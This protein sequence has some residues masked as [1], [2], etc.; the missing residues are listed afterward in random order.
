ML[1]LCAGVPARAATPA[2]KAAAAAVIAHFRSQKITDVQQPSCFIVQTWAQ[3]AYLEGDGEGTAWL[4]LKGGGWH[5]LGSD[6]G[7]IYAS[8]MVKRYG[9][10]LRS[11]S[12]FKPGSVRAPVPA[13]NAKQA[14]AEEVL[15][16]RVF[17]ARGTV[18]MKRAPP[19]G[20]CSSSTPPTA[21]SSTSRTTARPIPLPGASVSTRSPNANTRSRSIAAIPGPSSSTAIRANRRSARVDAHHDSAPGASVLYGVVD[22]VDEDERQAVGIDRDVDRRRVLDFDRHAAGRG[23]GRARVARRIERL[24]ERTGRRREERG[25]HVE[26]RDLEHP[27]DQPAEAER[28]V[29]R[30]AHE[31][32]AGRAVD[33]AVQQRLEVAANRRERRAELVPQ[34]REERIALAFLRA[35]LQSAVDHRAE[36]AARRRRCRTSSSRCAL[37]A[38]SWPPSSPRSAPGPSA[39][40][41]VPRRRCRHASARPAP[42][43]RCR[44]RRRAR[45]GRRLAAPA[46]PRSRTRP[47]PLARARAPRASPRR[48]ATRSSSGSCTTRTGYGSVDRAASRRSNASSRGSS[49]PDSAAC[50]LVSEAVDRL[51]E[52]GQL[53]AAPRA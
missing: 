30:D 22:E 49:P 13:P 42:R 6:G 48:H 7:V 1:A 44:C 35:V 23:G 29:V 26:Q 37:P 25:A 40:R 27:V 19:S 5:F 46:K 18:T 10:P 50:K 2:Q 45:R 8:M 33:V 17:Q 14:G 47:S 21:R 12:S 31:P 51:D 28:L 15:D 32:F 53:R 43:R 9:I 52:R 4:Q 11:R 38:A 20:D 41:S 16:L 3:C 34:R 24:P 39:R 36:I